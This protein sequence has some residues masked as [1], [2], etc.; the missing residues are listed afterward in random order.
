MARA[1]SS[2]KRI[3]ILAA[4]VHEIAR[5]GLGAST[6]KIA[7]R[8]GLATGTLFTYFAS[9]QELLNELYFDLK[10]EAYTR[11]N[12]NFPHR[13]GLERQAKHVW[14]SY[15]DWSIEFPEKR[16]V[17]AQL[18]VSDVVT[19]ETRARTAEARSYIEAT[20]RELSS[21]RAL[22]GLPEGFAAA[23]M[24]S[25]QEATMELIAKQPK[26]REEIARRAFRVFW[27]AVR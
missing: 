2:A 21:R 13:A 27:R 23:T 8:A 9:K 22:R 4:A 26:Q 19:P 1:R 20:L 17:A 12:S 7:G 15:L 14:S 10:V 25:L 5:T 3:A 18:N 6:A 11:I 16:K 24:A